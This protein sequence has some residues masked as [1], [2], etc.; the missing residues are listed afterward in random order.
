MLGPSVER[1]QFGLG[2]GKV[3]PLERG[4]Y[5]LFLQLQRDPQLFEDF[6]VGEKFERLGFC[7]VGVGAAFVDDEPV[8]KAAKLGVGD[9]LVARLI[10]ALEPVGNLVFGASARSGGQPVAS[11]I[12]GRT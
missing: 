6:V 5:I 12:T 3:G 4:Q 11:A 1:T 10:F 7:A 8:E 9:L 2:Y